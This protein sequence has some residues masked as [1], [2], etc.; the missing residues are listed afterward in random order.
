[1]LTTIAVPFWQNSV[2]MKCLFGGGGGG[3]GG[4]KEIT[5]NMERIFAKIAEVEKWKTPG[6]CKIDLMQ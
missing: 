5:G 2:L 4:Q 3:V 6:F 1:M